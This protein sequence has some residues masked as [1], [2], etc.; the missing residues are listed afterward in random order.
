MFLFLKKCGRFLDETK[1]L[2]KD[3]PN[4]T[5]RSLDCLTNEVRLYIPITAVIFILV[6]DWVSGLI[7]N[8]QTST[9]VKVYIT[10]VLFIS[11]LL[12]LNWVWTWKTHSRPENL[13]KSRQKSISRKKIQYFPWKLSKFFSLNCIFGHFKL[14][15]RSKID[16][17][18][19]LKLQ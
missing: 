17:W 2:T 9:E 3:E 15:S 18:P 7:R 13:K 8:L 14:F 4:R 5:A 6:L 11:A 16:F 10:I 19:F 12:V 1:I